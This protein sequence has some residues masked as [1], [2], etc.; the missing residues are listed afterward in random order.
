MYT[1][2][3]FCILD[4]AL[5]KTSKPGLLLQQPHFFLFHYVCKLQAVVALWRVGDEQGFL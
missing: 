5:L 3:L 4:A 1:V 2:R